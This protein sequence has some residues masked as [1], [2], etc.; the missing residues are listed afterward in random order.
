[1][2][3]RRSQTKAEIPSPNSI[4][5]I[6][7]SVQIL[8][9][10]WTIPLLRELSGGPRRPSQIQKA[11]HGISSK[12]LT[13]RLRQLGRWGL[14]SRTTISQKPL[15]AIYELTELGQGIVELMVELRKFGQV[16]LEHT[17]APTYRENATACADCPEHGLELNCPAV[18]DLSATAD[19]EPVRNRL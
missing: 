12:T 19:P 18:A 2:T 15:H 6:D 16:W 17:G 5:P 14:I 4:C 9:G 10:K 13:Q 1:M 3:S 7:I 8:S 11:L